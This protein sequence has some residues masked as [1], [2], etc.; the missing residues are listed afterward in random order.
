MCKLFSNENAIPELPGNFF[1][2]IFDPGDIQNEK[3]AFRG[4]NWCSALV[5]SHDIKL[6]TS[7]FVHYYY[8][9]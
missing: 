7:A 6:I 8:K 9:K 4:E 1:K 5:L 2:L 3:K